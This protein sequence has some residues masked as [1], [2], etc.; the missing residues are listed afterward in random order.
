MS[1]DGKGPKDID[2]F[3]REAVVTGE[4]VP[5]AKWPT[6]VKPELPTVEY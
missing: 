5:R 2:A 6:L 1:L 4:Y 3:L